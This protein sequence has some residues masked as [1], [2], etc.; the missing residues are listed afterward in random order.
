VSL[1]DQVVSSFDEP[2]GDPSAIPTYLV[3][4]LARGHVTVVLSGDGGDE[5]FSGYRRYRSLRRLGS[6]RW[7]PAALR[8]RLASILRGVGSESLQAQRAGAFLARS[9]KEFPKDYLDSVNYL[10]VP[11]ALQAIN[12]EWLRT[13]PEPG[14]DTEVDRSM[15]F[16]EAA[17]RLDIQHYLPEDILAKVDRMSMACSLEARVPLLD[18][19]LVEFVTALPPRWKQEGNRPKALLLESSRADLPSQVWN[20]PKMG[21][22]IPLSRWFRGH[23]KEYLRDVLLGER[24][25]SRGLWNPKGVEALLK[26]HERGTWDLSEH[27]WSILTVEVWWRKYLDPHESGLPVP[28]PAGNLAGRARMRPGEAIG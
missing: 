8:S 22:G 1:V 24:A 20:R 27:I 4:R 2:F 16:V 14:W 18:H 10:V 26:A 5:L 9:T 23:N 13:F 25:R 28:A 3:S 15:D 12:P 21:F 6:V 7:I 17:Q 11:Q 19:R